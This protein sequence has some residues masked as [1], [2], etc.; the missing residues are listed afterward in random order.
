LNILF[1]RVVVLYLSL[2][3]CD[4]MKVSYKFKIRNRKFKV[5][6]FFED[7]LKATFTE[8]VCARSIVVGYIFVLVW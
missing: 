4:D 5:T 3:K 6:T 7:S 2:M 1:S 8:M